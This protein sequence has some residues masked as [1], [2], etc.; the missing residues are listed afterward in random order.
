M[1]HCG[2][3]VASKRKPLCDS[4]VLF[5]NKPTMYVLM[6]SKEQLLMYGNSS[7]IVVVVLLVWMGVYGSGPLMKSLIYVV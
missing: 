7:P 6:T 1:K 3:L 4:L 5:E 2:F